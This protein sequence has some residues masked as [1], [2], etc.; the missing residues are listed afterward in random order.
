MQRKKRGQPKKPKKQKPPKVVYV[1]DSDEEDLHLPCI[2][3]TGSISCI[4]VF[5]VVS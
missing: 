5:C 4:F 3:R 2:L 1:T